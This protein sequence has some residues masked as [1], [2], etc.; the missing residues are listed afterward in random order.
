MKDTELL[1]QEEENKDC[2][3][4]N[5]C[6]EPEEGEIKAGNCTE[7]TYPECKEKTEDCACEKDNC[8]CDE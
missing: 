3:E 2:D 6:N 1:N 4:C 5:S 8:N 7:E